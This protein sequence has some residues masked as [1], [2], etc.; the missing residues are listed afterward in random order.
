MI[1]KLISL[2]VVLTI[3]INLFFV[4]ETSAITAEDR[5]IEVEKQLQAIAEQI[6]KYEGEK[7]DLEKAII[8]NL[9]LIHI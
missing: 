2:S 7:S 4:N 6:S 9:S 5:L 1:K 3:L 8:S